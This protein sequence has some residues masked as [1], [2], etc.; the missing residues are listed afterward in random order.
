MSRRGGGRRGR[1]DDGWEGWGGYMNAKRQKLQDQYVV[2]APDQKEGTE[3][4][5]IFAGVA[6]YVNGYT[7]PSS[8]ELKRLIILH[9]GRYEHYLY[10]TRVTH[11]IATNLPDSKVKDLKGLKVVRPEW[12]TDSIAAGKL[13]SYTR[14]QLY[15]AQSGLQKGLQT[16]TVQQQDNQAT[17]VNQSMEMNNSKIGDKRSLMEKK[18]SS[19]DSGIESYDC[20][21]SVNSIQS[22]G[23]SKST[24]SGISQMSDSRSNSNNKAK[25]T[26]KSPPQNLRSN[27]TNV[28]KQT[29][30]SPA[31][32]GNPKFLNE[33]YSN[34]RL[35]Y[36][37]TWK[38]EF[39]DYVNEIQN[40]EANLLGRE[41]LRNFVHSREITTGEDY[42][43]ETTRE[44]SS[45]WKRGKRERC[46]MHVDMDCF[47]VS[48]GLRK[49][50]DLKGKPVA[51]T[52]S[53][54]KGASV[55]PESDLG[56]EK[57]EW[58]KKGKGGKSMQKDNSSHRDS[59][60]RVSGELGF[61]D[62]SDSDSNEEEVEPDF[63]MA[64][65]TFHSMAEIA[66]CS[67]EARQ[68]GVKN[69]M[70]MGKARQLCPNL[71]TIPYDF[72]G[73]NQVSRILYDTVASYTHDI[74]AVSCDEML[75]D[76]TDL[77]A[78]TGATPLEFASMLRDEIFEKTGCHASAGLASNILLAKMATR[79]AKPNGQF[80]L[81][82]D[83]VSAYIKSQS[84]K[85]IPGIGWSLTKRFEAMKVTTC[86]DLQRLSPDTL[87]KELG[88]KTGQSL[89]RYCRG[90][91]DRPIKIEQQRKSV[92]AEVNY[93][94]RF[95]TNREADQFLQELSEEVCR[96]L[97][98]I[99]MKGK[100]ITLKL[101][102]RRQDAP[103]QTSKF[104][105]HGICNNFSKSVTLP[106]ATDEARIVGR[107]T[108]SLLKQHKVAPDD[109]RGIGIQI[110]KL[111]PATIGLAGKS[112]RSTS[113]LNFTVNRSVQA[114]KPSPLISHKS[115]EKVF[116]TGLA[117]SS[118]GGE[119][120]S[121]NAS[122]SGL[123]KSPLSRNTSASS[124]GLAKSPLSRNT[125]ASSSGLARSPINR[126]TS[127]SSSG[128]AKS[129]INRNT[130][131]SSSGLAKSPINRNTIASSSGLAKSLINR[132]TS[133]SSSGLARSPINRNTSASSSGLAR[134]PINRN[135]IASSSGLAKS[136]INRNTIA[137]SSGFAKSPIN[138]NTS[139]SSS[140]LAKSPMN[141]NTSSDRSS[142][143]SRVPVQLNHF[144]ENIGGI[145]DTI[146]DITNDND[147][148][149]YVENF[150]H[151]ARSGVEVEDN[152][153]NLSTH[154]EIEHEEIELPQSQGFAW[155]P[156][157][158]R[159]TILDDIG[160]RQK[161]S[162]E[163]PPLPCLP[164]IL[165]P[166]SGSKQA[167]AVTPSSGRIRQADDVDYFPSPSQV[168]IDVLSELPEDIR[169]Q[170]EQE[171][172]N[173]Q[174]KKLEKRTL[175]SSQSQE[176]EATFQQIEMGENSGTRGSNSG[177]RRGNSATFRGDNA[178]PNGASSS[179]EIRGDNLGQRGR[180][181]SGDA[182]V[183]LPSPSQLDPTCLEAL[184]E[185]L[186]A[187]LKEAYSRQ[188]TNGRSSARGGNFL[189]LRQASPTTSPNKRSPSKRS[190]G[191]R[192]PQFKVPRGRPGGRGR[193]RGST[194]K[195]TLF[196]GSAR[197]V[198]KEDVSKSNREHQQCSTSN[199]PA[200]EF[201]D[202]HHYVDLIDDGPSTSKEIAIDKSYQNMAVQD[203]RE[204][205]SL[206]N[207]SSEKVAGTQ[208]ETKAVNLCGAVT[209]ADVRLLLKE[210]I[211]STPNPQCED[212]TVLASYLH[213]LILER[214]LEQV[215]LVLKYMLRNIRKLESP[216]WMSSLRRILHQTQAL[217]IQMYGSRLVS[218]VV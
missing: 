66:S 26:V 34:S 70:F 84:V 172:A 88:P 144:D 92:S 23:S 168:D 52:H 137:S 14:Y 7:K 30:K 87:Q 8:D 76:C 187:E 22:L 111:E 149:L 157:E 189:N 12:I 55:D 28:P 1:G 127:A 193:P 97:T 5:N 38:S 216:D 36:L 153:E 166:E 47:F 148:V 181:H 195:K 152:K 183:A 210:W 182:I 6:I 58:A 39:K 159:N 218:I 200:L 188:A 18:T 155:M 17:N 83:L 118:I 90:Q 4:P 61:P 130:I 112:S 205:S 136:P 169:L 63:A 208:E 94:I 114:D 201:V 33:Y 129:P 80:H 54:G 56:F 180:S 217:T 49:R 107:E 42:S 199:L 75:V 74:E 108:I 163:L 116:P 10:R 123:A 174:K 53:R 185:F 103:K 100:T 160:Q 106:M 131:A 51:V 125:S 20:V 27:S 192:S 143:R 170:I 16:I 151:L 65:D 11:V 81:T 117:R 113:I 21:M 73:Y 158:Q 40:K 164:E 198:Q 133:A 15:T 122:S 41:R 109:L 37:S 13:L 67:Y 162:S 140:G 128:F 44:Y 77:L 213:D 89:Y 110:Q 142:V 173:R 45:A 86:G 156:Q 85:D 126:N 3:R 99:H 59:S 190:P 31:Y 211:D 32:A 119:K 184:P 191:K 203:T 93:G 214:N 46:V 124:S 57:R 120:T 135:T 68:A 79:K 50:P 171:M 150:G 121:M 178:S 186:Q 138:R 145:S 43:R 102:V 204:T 209:I 48:V 154:E 202:T 104:M 29:V 175:R 82:V 115:P 95:T 98:S 212:E 194:S 71:M 64:T 25:E 2:S 101:M 147:E 177:E 206:S 179:V 134:S 78:D 167:R 96:R 62:L 9:G 161:I 60:I 141:R 69:G 19:I 165:S 197:N 196:K 24:D 176:S 139:A 146:I 72:V 35:H 91:D 132:N 215:D 105:G 207:A